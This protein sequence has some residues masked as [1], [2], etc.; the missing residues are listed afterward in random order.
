LCGGLV[1]LNWYKNFVFVEFDNELEEKY[2]DLDCELAQTMVA[3]Q[4]QNIVIAHLLTMG[5]FL[6]LQI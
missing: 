3:Q 5:K 1:H 6:S 4:R 2:L